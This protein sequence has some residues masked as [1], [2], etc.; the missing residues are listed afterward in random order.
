MEVV[1]GGRKREGGREWA[2]GCACLLCGSASPYRTPISK[3]L[4]PHKDV[5][6][7]NRLRSAVLPQPH[8]VDYARSRT[9]STLRLLILVVR[10]KS[11]RGIHHRGRGRRG[12]HDGHS[13]DCDKSANQPLVRSIGLPHPPSPRRDAPRSTGLGPAIVEFAR[14]EQAPLIAMATHG[15]T[16][17][18]RIAVG[19]VTTRVVHDASCPIL[20]I[21]PAAL[22]D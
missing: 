1:H 9:A 12:L 15:R 17:L 4:R 20:T 6:M 14:R 16:G 8:N 18:R 7:I 19:S 2:L 3:H 10:H 13:L 22:H 5:A 11:G 21:R